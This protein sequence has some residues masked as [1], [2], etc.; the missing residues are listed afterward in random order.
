MVTLDSYYK[1]VC[2]AICIQYLF[3]ILFLLY[4][5]LSNFSSSKP[6][7]YFSLYHFFSIIISILKIA[8]F[9]FVVLEVNNLSQQIIGILVYSVYYTVFILISASW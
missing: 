9:T 2:L 5:L 7:N 1:I 3:L 4:N 6:L 8:V